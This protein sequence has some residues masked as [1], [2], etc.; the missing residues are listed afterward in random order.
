MP[1]VLLGIHKAGGAYVPLDP[2]YPA[3][4]TRFMVDDAR[5][6]VLLTQN[7]L[8]GRVPSR[9]PH[10]RKLAANVCTSDPPPTL[11]RDDEDELH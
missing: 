6:G 1:V 7:D 8:T 11:A 2:S 10:A 4:R 9:G 5:I 3:D